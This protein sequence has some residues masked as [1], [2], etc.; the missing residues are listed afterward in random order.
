M[1]EFLLHL[2]ELVARAGALH[3]PSLHDQLYPEVEEE[4]LGG[5]EGGREGGGE[6]GGEGGVPDVGQA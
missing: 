5:K 4:E 2:L 3:A 1:D 6:G